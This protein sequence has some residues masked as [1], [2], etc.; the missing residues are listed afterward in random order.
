MP[1]NLMEDAIT[2]LLCII[3][4]VAV[5]IV[6]RAFVEITGLVLYGD[7]PDLLR[8]WVKSHKENGG[9]G[10]HLKNCSILLI[11]CCFC[12]LHIQCFFMRNYLMYGR[13]AFVAMYVCSGEVCI[14]G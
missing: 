8:D 11:E 7:Q 13:K 5:N 10:L 3:V 1:R 4:I 9:L 12:S 2:M 14:E 6:D